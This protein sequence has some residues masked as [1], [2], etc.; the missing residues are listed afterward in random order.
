MPGSHTTHSEPMREFTHREQATTA[1]MATLAYLLHQYLLYLT[2]VRFRR[3][4]INAHTATLTLA[5]SNG[6]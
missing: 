4:R 1:V 6:A 3:W 2:I 5:D